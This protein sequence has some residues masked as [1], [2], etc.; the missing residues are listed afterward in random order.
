MNNMFKSSVWVIVILLV[1]A[2]IFLFCSS[3][4]L[5]DQISVF[6]SKITAIHEENISLETKVSYLTSLDF[7]K[8]K[9]EELN[10]TTL[11]YNP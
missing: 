7:A 6:E 4:G 10:F 3:I 5:S 11:K 9:A 1:A 2:N 8:V